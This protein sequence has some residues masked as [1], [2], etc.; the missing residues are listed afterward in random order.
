M[1]IPS[2]GK[3]SIILD[4][5]LIADGTHFWCKG[6]SSAVPITEQSANKK[7][8]KFCLSVI[9]EKDTAGKPRDR[10][11]SPKS[12]NLTV[13]TLTMPNSTPS[14]KRRGVKRK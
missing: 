6:H 11:E 14:V 4:N 7:F 12:P 9:S 13:L 1:E 8:C 3:F 2:S 10:Q 5:Q